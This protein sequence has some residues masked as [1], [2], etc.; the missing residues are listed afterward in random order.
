MLR[1]HAAT[2]STTDV[3][4]SMCVCYVGQQ[5]VCYSDM[6]A[7]DVRQYAREITVARSRVTLNSLLLEGKARFPLAELTWLVE[8]ARPSTWPM[9]TG[10]GNRSPVNSGSG[11]RALLTHCLVLP[12]GCVKIKRP[13]TSVNTP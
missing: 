7:V 12:T 5:S 8:T 4:V 2:I 11:N 1:L 6:P 9:L 3:T 13:S 10:N